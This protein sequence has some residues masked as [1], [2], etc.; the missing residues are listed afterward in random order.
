MNHLESGAQV[1][2]PA[3]KNPFAKHFVQIDTFLT[4][5]RL[6]PR[7]RRAHGAGRPPGA[8]GPRKEMLLIQ[9]APAGQARAQLLGSSERRGAA[10]RGGRLTW[11]TRR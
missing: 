11:G 10:R 4:D 1:A 6:V 7:E 8:N 9:Q 5:F 3:E 2:N